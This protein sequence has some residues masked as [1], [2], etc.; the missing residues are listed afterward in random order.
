MTNIKIKE[1]IKKDFSEL[2]LNLINLGLEKVEISPLIAEDAAYRLYRNI[3]ER[4]DADLREDKELRNILEKLFDD[5]RE[6]EAFCLKASQKGENEDEDYL[7][8]LSW[9]IL[10]LEMEMLKYEILM[11]LTS[12]DDPEY[13][14]FHSS[15]M[16]AL[17]ERDYRKEKKKE[18]EME[19]MNEI[20]YGE[21][22]IF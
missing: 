14:D 11:G 19:R 9:L 18:E 20:I 10:E 12:M 15:Y 7:V 22:F 1:Q 13:W 2:T 4:H 21:R 17:N 6:A 16:S 3:V 8:T 5:A